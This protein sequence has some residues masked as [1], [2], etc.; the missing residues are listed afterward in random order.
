MKLRGGEEILSVQASYNRK[1]PVSKVVPPF[2]WDQDRE[3]LEVYVLVKGTSNAWGGSWKEHIQ[4]HC[5]HRSIRVTITDLFGKGYELLLDGLYEEIAT[6][7]TNFQPK[8]DIVHI[9]VAKVVFD[10]F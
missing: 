10:G 1:G 5:T 9:K 2:G 4:L 6:I 7:P 8:K 3:Y